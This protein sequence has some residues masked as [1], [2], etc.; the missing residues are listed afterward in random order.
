MGRRSEKC[1][2]KGSMYA[3]WIGLYLSFHLNWLLGPFVHGRRQNL[4]T[5]EDSFGPEV[6]PSSKLRYVGWSRAH[7]GKNKRISSFWQFDS[8]SVQI[9]GTDCPPCAYSL[10]RRHD[11]LL[12]SLVHPNHRITRVHHSIRSHHHTRHHH[13]IGSHHALV[14]TEMRYIVW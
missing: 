5:S 12:V 13:L 9:E 2:A 1:V 4:K 11:W 8:N 3:Q 10:R 7:I 14:T 6:T